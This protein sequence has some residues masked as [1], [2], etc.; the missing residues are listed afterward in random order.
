MKL[1]HRRKLA[2]KYNKNIP[3]RFIC[4]NAWFYTIANKIENKEITYLIEQT[5]KIFAYT[6]YCDAVKLKHDRVM[7]PTA[8]KHQLNKLLEA[9][10]WFMF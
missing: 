7:T 1:S 9:V 10:I 4:F 8:F 3:Y 6:D 5:D 2:H